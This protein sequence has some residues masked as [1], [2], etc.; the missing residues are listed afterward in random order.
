MAVLAARRDRSVASVTL[1]TTLLDFDEPGEI[2]V[3][4]RV[5]CSPAASRC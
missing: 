1:L 4:V 2:G 5:N 3:Y